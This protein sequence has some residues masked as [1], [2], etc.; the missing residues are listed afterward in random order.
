M[1]EYDTM[2]GV[3]KKALKNNFRFD[4]VQQN[5]CTGG[6]PWPPLLGYRFFAKKSTWRKE[7]R[8][9][10]PARTLMFRLELK[11]MAII[12]FENRKLLFY[13]S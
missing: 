13:S 3:T 6:P 2:H 5:E 9:P 12:Q 10:R 1:F 8:A 11:K 7:G 4:R